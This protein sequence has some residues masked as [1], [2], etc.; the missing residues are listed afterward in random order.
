MSYES[1]QTRLDNKELIVLDG[2]IGTELERRGVQMDHASWSAVAS[3]EQS[4]VLKQIHADYIRAGAHIVTANT[5]SSSRPMLE[6]AGYGD[7]FDEVNRAAIE[8]A[9]RAR[10]IAGVEGIAV[11]GSLSH[12]TE[13]Y[14]GMPKPSAQQLRDTFGEMTGMMKACGVDLILLEMMYQPERIEIAA[15]AAVE[16]GLPVW[17]GFSALRGEDGRV[18]TYAP[19]DL[20]LEE[21]VGLA[22]RPGIVA[23]GLMHTPSDLIADGLE[24]VSSRFSGPVYAYPD[25]GYFKMP[26]W[27]FKEIEMDTLARFAKGWAETGVAAIGG[28]CGLTPDHI[29]AVS[30]GVAGDG[31]KAGARVR[32]SEV[33]KNSSSSR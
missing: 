22:D 19:H 6:A 12:W 29:R 18:L 33:G 25:S 28:C 7:R 30:R 2:G 23:A 9:Q 4:D 17:M 13:G 24:V 26:N 11:A 1:I 10:D 3:V 8:I 5:F 20:P 31:E 16:T 27:Q 15:A 21:I 14:P 32:R